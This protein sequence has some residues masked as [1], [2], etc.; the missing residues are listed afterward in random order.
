MDMHAA[1]EALEE[2]ERAGHDVTDLGTRHSAAVTHYRQI[3]QA[4]HSLDLDVLED[5]A[6]RVR[7]TTSDIR[8]AAEVAAEHRWEHKL[9]LVAVWFLA[10][11]VVVLAFFRLGELRR[12]EADTE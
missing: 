3:A 2:L 11:A 12:A 8:E 1:D 9:L 5:L 6:L 4:Q 7:S 10:L